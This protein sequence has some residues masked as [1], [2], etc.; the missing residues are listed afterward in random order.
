MLSRVAESI[1]WM[2]RYVERAENVARFIDVNMRYT[3]DLPGVPG[4]P[5]AP[6][7]P[8]SPGS[9]TQQWEPLVATT[10]DEHA[11]KERYAAATQENVVFF[12]TFDTHNP[13]SI[14]SCL[15]RA[16]ENGRSVREIISSE[17]WEHLNTSYRAISDVAPQAPGAPGAPVSAGADKFSDVGH[18]FYDRVKLVSLLFCGLCDNMFSRGEGWHFAYL[19]RMM[20]RADKTAR[21][22]DVK[23]YMLLPNKDYTG[24]PYDTLL[25]TALLR[26][27]S[28]FEM[29]RKR[30][31]PIDANRV[32][33]FLLLDREFPRS[34]RFC[35]Q[36]AE[37]SLASI[38][39][40]AAPRTAAGER[41][42]KLRGELDM[43]HI[44]E[45]MRRGLHEYLDRFEID[46]NE[47]D[48]AIYETFFARRI[49]PSGPFVPMQQQ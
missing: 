20:E 37:Q 14:L 25:W 22:L 5:G 48:D 21:I 17:M 36:Q 38:A 1:Y 46:L 15:H 6:G 26:S 30:H 19:G 10:A 40:S 28:A 7:A 23:S 49:A 18:A 24:T 29:Y 2:S 12:L 13:N 47:I 42:A 27:A 34:I 41:L 3:L 31:G 39:G 8:G 16:R 35:I 9:E 32:A 11:F 33:E 43:A 45:I 4:A 44:S